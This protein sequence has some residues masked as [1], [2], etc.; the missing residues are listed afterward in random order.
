MNLRLLLL[1]ALSLAGCYEIEHVKDT[2]A[3]L[4]WDPAAGTQQVSLRLHGVSAK[5]LECT[6][7]A[8]CLARIR[9]AGSPTPEAEGGS[10]TPVADLA[11]TGATAITLTTERVGGDL[12]LVF[13]YTAPVG[14]AGATVTDVFVEREGKARPHLVVDLVPGRT[15]SAK[16]RTR[17]RTL[18]EDGKPADR[19]T[20]VL[21]AKVR[22]IEVRTP[23][24]PDAPSILTEIPGLDAALVAAGLLSA[25]Q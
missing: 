2:T 1:S 16:G 4:T 9:R 18:L 14:S 7:A 20:L 25:A 21:P 3:K 24:E 17:T 23:I 5:Y 6:D 8:D 19:S 12:D 13:A 22:A 10:F 11:K 15:V